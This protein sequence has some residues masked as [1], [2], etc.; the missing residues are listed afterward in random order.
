MSR[1]NIAGPMQPSP[2]RRLPDWP[3]RLGQWAAQRG[4]RPFAWGHDDCAAW[5][6]DAVAALH[7]RDTL[8][9]LRGTRRTRLQARRQLRRIGGYTAALARA[10]LQPVPPALAQRGDVVLLQ[11]D[12][13]AQPRH[14]LD[15]DADLQCVLAVCLGEDAAAP[16]PAGLALAPMACAVRAWRV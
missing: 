13:P 6:A 14:T 3:A 4:T 12:T 5:V 7:G 9:E 16:G 11:P 8:A 15:A 2:P 10:G 1:P